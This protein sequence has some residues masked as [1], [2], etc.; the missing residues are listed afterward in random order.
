MLPAVWWA[1]IDPTESTSIIQDAVGS[2]L[3]SHWGEGNDTQESMQAPSPFFLHDSTTVSG[4]PT[5][6]Q[7]SFIHPPSLPGNDIFPYAQSSSFFIFTFPMPFLRYMLQFDLIWEL[8]TVH[9][10]TSLLAAPIWSPEGLGFF[11]ICTAKSCTHLDMLMVCLALCL[12]AIN[13]LLSA[14]ASGKDITINI[15]G[16]GDCFRVC[17]N[18]R[19]ESLD[20]ATQT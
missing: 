5:P 17:R 11:F 13:F 20:L 10:Y 16:K 19:S 15:Y 9:Y 8:R 7:L 6:A 18:A 4:F 1:C 3:V 2:M 12:N 14:S